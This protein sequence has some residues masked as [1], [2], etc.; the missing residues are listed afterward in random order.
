MSVL[1]RVTVFPGQPASGELAAAIVEAGRTASAR[2]TSEWSF[3]EA[4]TWI[5][6]RSLEV[7]N[8]VAP[9]HFEVAPIARQLLPNEPSYIEYIVASMVAE[10]VAQTFCQCERKIDCRDSV[11]EWNDL[12][13]EEQAAAASDP[14]AKRRM[15]YIRAHTHICTC[16]DA[17][18]RALFVAAA[19][20]QVIATAGVQREPISRLEWLQADYDLMEGLQL[21]ARRPGLVRFR[22]SAIRNRW[23]AQKDCGALPKGKGRPNANLQPVREAFQERRDQGL[24]LEQSQ[25]REWAACIAIAQ[26]R[27]HA[28]LPAPDTCRRHLG[29]V[30]ETACANKSG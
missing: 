16:F 27:G 6:T 10:A 1:T 9:Y 11:K 19:N 17:A 13:P 28:D 12:S 14:T 4:V 22:P 3:L 26:A 25:I 7:V 18:M 5:A 30:Y 2:T 24:A 21:G 20:E 15:L 8:G 23:P 29:K